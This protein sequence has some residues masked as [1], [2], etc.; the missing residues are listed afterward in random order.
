MYV[1]IYMHICRVNG[2]ANHG[3]ATENLQR[4][5]HQIRQG[6]L[7][8]STLLK[9]GALLKC[10]YWIRRPEVNLD[11]RRRDLGVM[12]ISRWRPFPY[13]PT[14]R[15]DSHH[16]PIVHDLG[17]VWKEALKRPEHLATSATAWCEI[18]SVGGSLSTVEAV[19]TKTEEHEDQEDNNCHCLLVRGRR[20]RI[21]GIL[22]Q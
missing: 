1:C 2:E 4:S 17:R 18:E 20:R 8:D 5:S 7:H 10:R 9:V 15:G 16:T 6:D 13:N 19:D 14:A 11:T 12:I 22:N 3:E 21:L